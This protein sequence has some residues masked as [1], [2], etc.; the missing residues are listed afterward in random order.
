MVLAYHCIFGTYGFW[1]PTDPRGSWSDHV[2]RWDLFQFGPPKMVQTRQSVAH[3]EHDRELRNAAKRALK[4]PPVSFTGEQALAVGRAFQKA[5]DEGQ[6]VF[7][8]CSVLPEHVH[9]VIGRHERPIRT[10]VG[11]LKSTA[12]RAV[13]QHST[14]PADKRP[15]WGEGG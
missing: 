11:H 3:A 15:V 8:A 4:Y 5:S 12:T 6:D 1:L 2:A 10:I 14:W 7:H 9:L 13:R